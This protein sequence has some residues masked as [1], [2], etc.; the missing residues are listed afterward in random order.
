VR[1]VLVQRRDFPGSDPLSDEER[2]QLDGTEHLEE[3]MTQ[4]AKDVHDFLSAFVVQNSIPKKTASGGGIILCTWSFGGT[5]LTAFLSNAPSFKGGVD[6][7]DYV[8]QAIL[9]GKQSS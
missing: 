8:K 2:A 7:S 4:R 5:W 1:V 3:Y 6:L 9:Y